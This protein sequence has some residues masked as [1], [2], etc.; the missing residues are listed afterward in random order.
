MGYLTVEQALAD[1]AEFL[2]DFKN[3]TPGAKDSPVVV[4]GGSYGGKLL[5]LIIVH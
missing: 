4:F 3:E 2:T 1:Y 5:I